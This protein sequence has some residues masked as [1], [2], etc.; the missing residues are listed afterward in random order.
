[1]VAP[2][3]GYV[4]FYNVAT[5][6]C[7]KKQQ[8]HDEGERSSRSIRSLST[9]AGE[10]LV[11]S[12]GRCSAWLVVRDVKYSEIKGHE[13]AVIALCVSDDGSTSATRARGAGTSEAV[14]YTHLTLPTICSV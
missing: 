12:P 14:S 4:Y 3:Q 1:M 11:S 10:L 7:V 5:E 13:G 8:L 2:A 9:V 6:R